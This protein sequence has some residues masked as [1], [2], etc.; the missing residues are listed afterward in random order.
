[1]VYVGTVCMYK[2][3]DNSCLGS[4]NQTHISRLKSLKHHFL[5]SLLTGMAKLYLRESYE[6]WQWNLNFIW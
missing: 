4:K 3:K 5:L 2:A 1:M 6:K